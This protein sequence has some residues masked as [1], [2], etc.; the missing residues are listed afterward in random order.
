MVIVP[1]W[2]RIAAGATLLLGSFGA[3]WT[4]N[5]WRL[6]Q[7]MESDRAERAEMA[8]AQLKAATTERDHVAGL[9][10]ASDTKHAKELDD[11]RKETNRV[12]DAVSAGSVRLRVAARCPDVPQAPA[13]ASSPS[14]DHGAGAEL[15]GSARQAYFALRDGIDRAGAQLAACQGELRLRAQ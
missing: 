10:V 12:R 4:V 8:A 15:D 2:A 6:G 5:G 3:G 7:V 14:V 9:L 11:A 13:A 1:P